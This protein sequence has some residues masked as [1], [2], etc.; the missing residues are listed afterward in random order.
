[1]YG[2]MLNKWLDSVLNKILFFSL[3]V[4]QPIESQ[5]ETNP[6]DLVRYILNSI[7]K[8]NNQ[9]K[10]IGKYLHDQMTNISACIDQLLNN[11]Q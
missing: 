4:K 6:L 9:P 2:S 3:K 10:S 1:M 7:E 5:N 11:L 8:C